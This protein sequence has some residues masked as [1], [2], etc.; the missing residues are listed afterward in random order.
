[1]KMEGRPN[2][3]QQEIPHPLPSTRM[4]STEVTRSKHEKS[5]VRIIY[6]ISHFLY[7]KIEKLSIHTVLYDSEGFLEE[8]AKSPH[9]FTEDLSCYQ[10][11][12][13]AVEV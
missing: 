10:E 9:V 12:T 2:E 4:S 13:T 6:L 7:N 1:M 5:Y 11:V 8:K 3:P